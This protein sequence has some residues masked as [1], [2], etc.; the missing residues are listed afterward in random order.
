MSNG[1]T[2]KGAKLEIL[3]KLRI[4][5]WG[6]LN[7]LP[8]ILATL[9]AVLVIPYLPINNQKYSA[10][11]INKEKIMNPGVDKY[12]YWDLNNDGFSERIMSSFHTAIKGNPNFI[13]IR[14]HDQNFSDDWIIKGNILRNAHFS[15]GDYNHDSIMEVYILSQIKD[16]LFIQLINP[17]AKDKRSFQFQFID[18]ISH[19]RG[20]YD[21]ASGG[22]GFEDFNGDG[23]DE[24]VFFARGALC[25]S[26]RKVYQWDIKNRKISSSINTGLAFQDNDCNTLAD[27]DNDGHT[28]II[29]SNARQMNF[30]ELT[31]SI[32]TP[33]LD[34]A[35]WLI[36]FDQNLAT[37]FKPIPLNGYSSFPIILKNNGQ[38][39]ICLIDKSQIK[40]GEENEH[41][42]RIFRPD[43]EELTPITLNPSWG[44]PI[45]IINH[46]LY[47]DRFSIFFRAGFL[48]DFSFEGKLLDLKNVDAW[49]IQKSNF[50]INQDGD[51]ENICI[52]RTHPFFFIYD[53]NFKHKIAVEGIESVHPPA[54]YFT[55]TSQNNKTT[56]FFHDLNYLYEVDYKHNDNY[57][58]RFLFWALVYIFFLMIIQLAL[59]LQ[60]RQLKKKHETEKLLYRHQMLSI[61]NQVD[62]H[63]TLNAINGISGMYLSGRSEEANRFLTKFSRL[64]HRSLMESENI[65]TTVGEEL[66]FITDYLDIQKIRFKDLFEYEI[67]IEDESLNELKI[68]RQLIHTFVENAIKHGIRSL[69]KSGKIYIEISKEADRLKLIIDDNGI[70]RKAASQKESTG[71]GL[72]IVD[73]IIELYEK[74]TKV[75]F[76]Y[77]IEDK[78]DLEGNALGTRVVVSS[79]QN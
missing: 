43:G 3:K 35:S 41:N 24:F 6:F 60:K 57:H 27:I 23:Y 17:F 5:R 56:L 55:K 2:D 48:G 59:F 76:T 25:R 70:G 1:F 30:S 78:H 63:F 51:G 40:N 77:Q 71:K 13:N 62:P 14:T 31:D 39:Y 18:T 64:I 16:S 79:I 61:K 74:L 75:K 7:L 28:E 65:E 54:Y 38:N 10:T 73:Q 8:F 58:F 19:F 53:E 67:K 26:P 47:H 12:A 68:P 20:S 29:I 37:K 9:P 49:S 33:Y 69:A 4:F 15:F 34:T 42:V 46:Q 21:V 44:R 72:K 45:Q 11:L 36:V 52:S 32:S 50:D 22:I 66:Q